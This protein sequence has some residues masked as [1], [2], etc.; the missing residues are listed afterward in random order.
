MPGFTISFPV[1]DPD[2]T[3]L[4]RFIQRIVEEELRRELWNE[5]GQE[6]LEKQMKKVFQGK[7]GPYRVAEEIRQKLGPK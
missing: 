7:S 6:L 5:R 2:Q 4:K 1:H 3:R